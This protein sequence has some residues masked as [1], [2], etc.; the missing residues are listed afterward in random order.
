MAPRDRILSRPHTQ[1][2]LRPPTL[3]SLTPLAK[4]HGLWSPGGLK[5]WGHCL[6]S[7]TNRGRSLDSSRRFSP[8]TSRESLAG[9]QQFSA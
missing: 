1:S 6:K 8:R 9:P 5:E 3:L 2:P 4:E 7:R